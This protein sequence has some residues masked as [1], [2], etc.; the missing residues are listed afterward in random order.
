MLDRVFVSLKSVAERDLLRRCFGC[1]SVAVILIDAAL[2]QPYDVL[3]SLAI[4]LAILCLEVASRVRR[5]PSWLSFPIILV[6]IAN[7]AA[8]VFSE[9]A[10]YGWITY[11]NLV[12]AGVVALTW[13]GLPWYALVLTAILILLL[14]VKG[15][16]L[17]SGTGLFLAQAAVVVLFNFGLKLILDHRNDFLRVSRWYLGLRKG[18]VRHG[19]HILWL[20]VPALAALTFGIWL[21][22]TLQSAITGWFYSS[23]L[24][25]APANGGQRLL[26]R[27]AYSTLEARENRAI[28]KIEL[29][30][31]EAE[32]RSRSYLD[33]ATVK[34]L[35]AVDLFSPTAPD[36]KDACSGQVFNGSFDLGGRMGRFRQAL[37]GWKSSHRTTRKVAYKVDMTKACEDTMQKSLAHSQ[38]S[39]GVAKKKL[40]VGLDSKK[41][42]VLTKEMAA[43]NSAKAKAMKINSESFSRARWLLAM[44]FRAL[45]IITIASWAFVV[46]GFLGLIAYL[47]GRTSFDGNRG[48]AFSLKSMASSGLDG[49]VGRALQCSVHDR[50]DLTSSREVDGLARKQNSWHVSFDAAR[51]GDNT[52]MRLCI[53][54][55]YACFFRRMF[56]SRLL[57]TFVPCD[58]R[59]KHPP[60]ISAPGDLQLVDC[61]VEDGSE[62][63]FKMCDLIAFSDGVKLRSVY[64][65]HVATELLGLGAFYCVASGKGRLV[66]CSQG[67]EVRQSTDG[68]PLPAGQFL[69]WGHSAMFSLAQEP[70]QCGAWL[71]TPSL[72]CMG[73]SEV[74]YDEG[75]PGD[76]RISKQIWRLL[77]F[78]ASPI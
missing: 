29:V 39:Y 76:P 15:Y 62:I 27:D 75:R 2:Q 77:R 1:L 49:R 3:P 50:L 45:K 66:L 21:N 9:S 74:I 51:H 54:Q 24:V 13:I 52:H 32:L 5:K 40:E 28:D 71:N 60:I 31:S 73:D 18:R 17:W 55:W 67:R 43:L 19:L 53:P 7:I 37:G 68:L 34:T 12:I 35:W 57:L 11:A 23:G 70:S 46:A 33:A 20:S 38:T 59:R 6:C 78:A 44:T 65:M 64:S 69:A 30:S 41:E 72:K 58:G 61:V 56:D 4:L 63:V 8:V 16:G 25:D 48:V 14:M 36:I 42:E 10:A 47:F 26:E 22:V